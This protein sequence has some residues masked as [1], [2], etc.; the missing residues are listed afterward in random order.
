L[1]D[2]ARA[3]TAS[4]RELLR[5]HVELDDDAHEPETARDGQYWRHEAER[6]RD[7]IDQLVGLY[8]AASDGRGATRSRPAARRRPP[9]SRR[10]SERDD[11]MKKAFMFLMLSELM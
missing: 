1:R 3:S 11:F 5:G 6:I 4:I 7:E 2:Q 10:P 9:T 8:E